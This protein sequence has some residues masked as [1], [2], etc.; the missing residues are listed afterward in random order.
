MYIC[1]VR[2][3]YPLLYTSYFFPFDLSRILPLSI[4]TR[5]KAS[6]RSRHDEPR[7]SGRNVSARWSHELAPSFPVAFSSKSEMYPNPVSNEQTT[8]QQ[9]FWHQQCSWWIAE[10]EPGLMFF[11]PWPH[12]E[13]GELG[14]F[15]DGKF[16]SPLFIKA[17]VLKATLVRKKGRLSVRCFVVQKSHRENSGAGR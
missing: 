6:S 11:D 10:P 1:I 15:R 8:Y 3:S 13:R 14:D 16:L 17:L 9:D 7:F 4:D 5:A 2:I 12:L